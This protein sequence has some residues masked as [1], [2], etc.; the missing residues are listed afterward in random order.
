LPDYVVDVD[1]DWT[2]ELARIRDRSDCVMLNEQRYL[3]R[4]VILEIW[5]SRHVVSASFSSIVDNYYLIIAMM[6]WDSAKSLLMLQ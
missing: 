2:A 4:K 5:T 3:S 6:W 1:S